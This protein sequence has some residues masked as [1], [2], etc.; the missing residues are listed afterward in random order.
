MEALK[1]KKGN[2]SLLGS[3]RKLLVVTK[4]GVTGGTGAWGAE[5]RET[6]YWMFKRLEWLTGQLKFNISGPGVPAGVSP[7]PALW[8][9]WC[10]W[11]TFLAAGCD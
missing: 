3:C 1:T 11:C 2:E 7:P 9:L 4:S 10:L 6:G 5:R 8:V